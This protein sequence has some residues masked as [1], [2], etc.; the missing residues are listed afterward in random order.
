VVDRGVAAI[1]PSRNGTIVDLPVREG[2][3][4]AAGATL[5]RIRAEEDL[6]GGSSAPSRVI[7]SEEHTSEL[8]SQSKLVCRLLLV[9]KNRTLTVDP[10]A[11]VDEWIALYEPC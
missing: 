4:V 11:F 6:S 8:Q 1:V 10:G 5:A 2:Q 9:K 3:R 7:R